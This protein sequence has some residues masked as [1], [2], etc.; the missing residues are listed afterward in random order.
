M[1]RIVVSAPAVA[2]A[3]VLGHAAGPDAYRCGNAEVD[4]VARLRVGYLTSHTGYAER[5][6]Q[7]AVR[8]LRLAGFILRTSVDAGGR[9][10][11][12]DP[13]HWL[14]SYIRWSTD[15]VGGDLS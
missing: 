13:S 10:Y 15:R 6:V 5:T 7:R 1:T 2:V 4:Y 9:R 3:Q 11:D 14:H 12:L 8:D